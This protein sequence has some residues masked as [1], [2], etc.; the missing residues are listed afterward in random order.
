MGR[1]K[2]APMKL[3][4]QFPAPRRAATAGG[5]GSAFT[6]LEVII[7]CAIFF[8]VAFAVLSTVAQCLAAA[9]KLEQHDPDPALL[10]TLPAVTNIL[11][12]GLES[13]DFDESYP[14]LFP[15]WRWTR[16]V[17]PVYD[18]TNGIYQV[19]IEV[20]RNG[21]GGRVSRSL[22]IQLFKPQ[23]LTANPLGGGP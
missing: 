11:T 10:A 9:R 17:V 12:V 20:Y 5:V 23:T 18:E 7:A 6:L 22:S 13:G 8:M 16:E 15:G 3:P 21:Q 14:N 1:S 2:N 4:T 19:N